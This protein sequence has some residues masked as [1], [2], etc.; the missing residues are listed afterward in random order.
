MVQ[1]LAY[2]LLVKFSTLY[3]SGPGLVP[4]HRPLPLIGSHAVVVTHIQNRRRLAQMLAQ[5]KSSQQRK[6]IQCNQKY[7]V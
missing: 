5:G 3:F 7:L 6:K 2:G 1:G 4:G